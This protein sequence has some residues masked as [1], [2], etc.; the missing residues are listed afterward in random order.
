[1]DF[2]SIGEGGPVEGFLGFIVFHGF[3]WVFKQVP[4]DASREAKNGAA[5]LKSEQGWTKMG[6]PGATFA[7]F[8]GTFGHVRHSFAHFY[9]LYQLFVNDCAFLLKVHEKTQKLSKMH[10]KL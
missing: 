5:G 4:A 6:P 2:I 3:P 9:A 1:M 7:H 8:G 10:R